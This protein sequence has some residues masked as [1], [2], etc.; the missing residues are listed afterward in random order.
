MTLLGDAQLAFLLVHVDG[1][2]LHGWPPR[3]E[4]QRTSENPVAVTTYLE[5]YESPSFDPAEGDS[6]LFSSKAFVPFAWFLFFTPEDFGAVRSRDD[7][8]D[9]T[10]LQTRLVEGV[11][12]ARARLVTLEPLASPE[13]LALLTRFVDAL[14]TLGEGLLVLNSHRLEAS[15]EELT[16]PLRW[17]A[18]LEG[19]RLSEAQVDLADELFEEGGVVFGADEDDGPSLDA[20]D[21]PGTIIG[22]AG[23][24]EL[25]RLTEAPDERPALSARA[26]CRDELLARVLAAP[27]SLEARMVCADQVMAAGDPLGEFIRLQCVEHRTRRQEKRLDVLWEGLA[28]ELLAPFGDAAVHFHQGFADAVSYAT[29]PPAMFAGPWW[30]TVHSVTLRGRPELLVDPVFRSVRRVSVT[31][32]DV[33]TLARSKGSVPFTSVCVSGELSNTAWRGL[34]TSSVFPALLEVWVVHQSVWLPVGGQ[35]L[36]RERPTVHVRGASYPAHDSPLEL[37]PVTAEA[38]R[39]RVARWSAPPQGSMLGGARY[40]NQ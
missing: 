34:A 31:A 12:L 14:A 3:V 21:E 40:D 39:A 8:S 22:W 15:K 18:T 19:P 29:P 32:S 11:R 28:E 6:V 37:T 7:G 36:V 23:Y 24:D 25:E 9:Y 33:E 17:L 1:Y 5:H 13:L 4:D 16:A 30:N 20:C 35:G 2:V 10:L 27:E 26:P 38:H